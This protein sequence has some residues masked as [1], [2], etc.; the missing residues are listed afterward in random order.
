[1]ARVAEV[2]SRAMIA[3][4]HVREIAKA[5]VFMWEESHAA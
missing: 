2:K 4:R 1:M 3:S 5:V